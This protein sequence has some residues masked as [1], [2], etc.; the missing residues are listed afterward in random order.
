MTW[1]HSSRSEL[2][3]RHTTPGFHHAVRLVARLVAAVTTRLD[4]QGVERVPVQGAFVGVSNHLSS[5]DPLVVLAVMPVRPATAFAAIEHRR[6][7]LVG[8]ALDR[9]GV[10]WIDRDN[11]SRDALRIARNELAHGTAFGIA[12]EGTRSRRV[13]LL[14]GKTGAAYLATRAGV[15]IF[16]A[17]IWGTEKVVSNLR[18]LR[19]TT[20]HFRMGEPIHLPRGRASTEELEEYTELIM[21]RIAS[22][23]PPEYRGVYADKNISE[24]L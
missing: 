24:I 9:L 11:P 18:R 7:F 13:G 12:P 3:R 16:P 23:L 15:P 10:I 5:F 4:A 22:M 14:P 8:W 20:V 6:D 1:P 17:A 19:R 21:R 2:P